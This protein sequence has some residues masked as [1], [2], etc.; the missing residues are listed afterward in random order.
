MLVFTACQKEEIV[1]S[2]TLSITLNPGEGL[3]TTNFKGLQIGIVKLPDGTTQ[4]DN[5]DSLAWTSEP[6]WLIST[7]NNEGVVV[8]DDIASGLYLVQMDNEALELET[9]SDEQSNLFISIDETG[10]TSESITVKLKKT[11]NSLDV[12]SWESREAAEEDWTINVHCFNKNN[13]ISKSY[14]KIEPIAEE[15]TRDPVALVIGTMTYGFYFSQ[16]IEDVYKYSFPNH[17][18]LRDEYARI[19]IEIINNNDGS[20]YTEVI[21]PLNEHWTSYPMIAEEKIIGNNR[22]FLR[23]SYYNFIGKEFIVI[24]AKTYSE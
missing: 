15:D 19:H 10:R 5:L 11:D 12:T 22:L 24:S 2:N 8:F 13:T 20:S 4:D 7:A 17:H 3:S 1:L 9:F 23:A 21:E 16:E 14:L 18:Y 6:V